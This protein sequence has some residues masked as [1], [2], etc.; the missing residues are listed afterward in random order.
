MKIR[1]RKIR[2]EEV[3][4]VRAKYAAH[5]DNLGEYFPA[6]PRW[7]NVYVRL[8]NGE[9]TGFV[10]S[11]IRI[12]ASHLIDFSGKPR[13]VAG[14]VNWIDGQLSV[15]G[16]YI[17]SVPDNNPKFQKVIERHFDCQELK[18]MPGKIYI[19]RRDS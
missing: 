1:Y 4:A 16:E 5:Y 8:E 14:M 9:I 13:A 18:L 15:Y 6:E 2:A 19:V 3:E 10:C 11:E 7:E 12:V 17:F